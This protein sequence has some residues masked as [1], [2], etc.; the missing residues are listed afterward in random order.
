MGYGEGDKH[1]TGAASAPP[2]TK[3]PQ[4]PCRCRRK[5]NGFEI[6]YIAISMFGSSA[7][8]TITWEGCAWCYVGINLYEKVA[9]W[10][11]LR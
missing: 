4:H 11:G 7:G 9:R 5:Q 2:L 8:H 3:V 6:F 1:R 10:H